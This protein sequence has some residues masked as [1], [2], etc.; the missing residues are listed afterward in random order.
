MSPRRTLVL[1]GV[2]SGKS[3]WAEAEVASW[4]ASRAAAGAAAAGVTAQVTYLATAPDRPDD[5][6][7]ADRVAAHRARRPAAWR[8]VETGDLAGALRAAGAA[9]MLL[10]DD[11]GNWLARTIDAAAGWSDDRAGLPAVRAAMDALVA[12]WR[13]TAG[14]VV[15]VSNEVGSGVVP[16]TYSGRLFRDELG[17]L[18]TLLAAGADRVVLLV[19]GIPMMLREREGP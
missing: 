1:G 6:E 10:V 8:T 15:L 18:N 19:A 14:P 11:L 4:A 13:D 7:W 5:P 16:A 9:G 17:R 2:R 12:A 3:A